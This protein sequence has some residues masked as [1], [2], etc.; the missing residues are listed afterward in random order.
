MSMDMTRPDPIYRQLACEFSSVI[1]R[2]QLKPG[3]RLPSVRRLAIQRHVSIS[4]ALQ[5]LRTLENS[6][7]IEARPQSGYFVRCLRVAWKSRK[8]AGRRGSRP[9]LASRAWSPA[10]EKPRTTPNIVAF[11]TAKPRS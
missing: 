2:G 9:M 7:L 5:T 4:T 6:G 1:Q 11:G 3:E 8:R 10:F